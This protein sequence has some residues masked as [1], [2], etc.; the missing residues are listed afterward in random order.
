MLRPL[1]IA[2]ACHL[3]P[4]ALAQTPDCS[5]TMVQS[6]LNACAYADWEEADA[7]LN[8]IYVEAVALLEREDAEFPIPEA[9]RL[10]ALRDAQRAWVTFRDKSCAVESYLWKGGS[11]EPLATYGCLRV[12]TEERIGHLRGM[13]EAWGG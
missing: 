2:F 12:L 4:A 10:E 3:A 13:I 6:E 7:R 5:N 9:S 1:T 8:N 11:A